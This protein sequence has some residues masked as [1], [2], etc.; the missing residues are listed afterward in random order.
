MLRRLSKRWIIRWG[1]YYEDN[2]GVRRE[3]DHRLSRSLE[4]F[5]A[6]FVRFL[7]HSRD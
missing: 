5:E 2:K 4:E 1:F 7:K 6:R 3:G